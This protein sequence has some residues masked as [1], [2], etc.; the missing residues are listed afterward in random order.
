MGGYQAVSGGSIPD[1]IVQ[2]RSL[3]QACLPVETFART[4]PNLDSFRH[5][6]GN[7]A[8]ET[9]YSAL[10]NR[11]LQSLLRALLR[12]ADLR[13]HVLNAASL[14]TSRG[15]RLTKEKQSLR[16]TAL[17]RYICECGGRAERLAVR[18]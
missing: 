7:L 6:T 2:L 8:T 14:E 13:Q 9:L 16:L 10:T 15:F 11:R 5:W 17:W 4:Q 1:A 12:A 18:S 3:Q